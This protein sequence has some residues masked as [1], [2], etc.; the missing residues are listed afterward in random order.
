MPIARRLSPRRAGHKLVWPIIEAFRSRGGGRVYAMPC[1]WL[2]EGIRDVGLW[3]PQGATRRAFQIGDDA[4]EREDGASRDARSDEKLDQVQDRR[5]GSG[6]G[7]RSSLTPI[8]VAAMRSNRSI[9]V[10]SMT[11]KRRPR[12]SGSS[13]TI[14]IGL[15]IVRRE[16]L[17]DT[18]RF[19]DEERAVW[20]EADTRH[21]DDHCPDGL[22]YTK[23]RACR[24]PSGRVRER[25]PTARRRERS[26]QARAPTAMRCIVG[27]RTRRTHRRGCPHGP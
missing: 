10:R 6:R 2:V 24:E 15:L 16:G 8:R 20:M 9:V 26:S 1:S 25:V 7:V 23:R 4:E 5:S 19:S 18:A 22:R 27:S 21:G 3:P 13:E 11:F 17:Q 12:P 14:A